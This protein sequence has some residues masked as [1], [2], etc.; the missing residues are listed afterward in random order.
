MSLV[1]FGWYGANNGPDCR[2]IRML[3]SK[4]PNAANP[5]GAGQPGAQAPRGAPNPALAGAVNDP[6][7]LRELSEKDVMNILD[8]IRKEFKC[9]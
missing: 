2:P 6:P 9:R 4:D 5:P 7:N 8:M 1:V 3:A